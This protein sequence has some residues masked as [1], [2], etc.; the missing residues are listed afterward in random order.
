MYKRI[1]LATIVIMLAIVISSCGL[2][3]GVSIEDRILQ[4]ESDLNGDRSNI[5]DNFYSG[6]QNYNQL[7]TSLYWNDGNS[8]FDVSNKNFDIAVPSDPGEDFTTTY[9][10][11]SGGSGTLTIRFIMEDEGSFFSGEDW[12]IREV[13]DG[14]GQQIK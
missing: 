1:L 13:W 2:F 5:I 12:K 11:N 3:F 14:F 6:C 4:F 9:T 7:N 8:I 10:S